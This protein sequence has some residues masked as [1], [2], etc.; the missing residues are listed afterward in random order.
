M[1]KLLIIGQTPPPYVGQMLSIE[2]LITAEYKDIRVYHTRLNYSQTTNQIGKIRIRKLFHLLRV[3]LESSY[4]ILRHRIDVIYY[5]PGADTVPILRDIATLLVLRRFGRKLILVFHASGLCERVSSW[6]EIL[7]WIFK[8]AFFFPDA[9]IQKSSL[10]P[11]D[12]EFIKAMTIYTVPNGSPDEFE[13]FRKRKALNFVPVIL[14]V[15]LIR[16]DKGVEVLIEAARLLKARGQ[17]FRVRL[18][19]EFTSEKYHQKLLREVGKKGLDNCVDFCGRKVGDEKWAQY[20]SADI[21]CFPTYYG[22]ESFGNVLVEAMMF[23]LPVVSTAWRGIPGIV[24]EGVTGFLTEVK[25]PAAVAKRLNRLL[26]DEKLRMSMGRAGRER[27]LEEF[28]LEAYLE[29]TRAV[30]LEVANEK[31]GPGSI[32][33]RERHRVTAEAR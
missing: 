12:G 11:P 33:S 5:P 2:S 6:P 16:E 15:G 20:R 7:F 28:T 25:D 27:Y 26:D 22:S 14:F 30:V 8:K 9:A 10:N 18:M 32:K 13:R 29:K 3:I 17:K 31:H 19:G 23:E 24:E 1:V 21:F 4:K